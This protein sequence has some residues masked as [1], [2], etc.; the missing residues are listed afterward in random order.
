[1]YFYKGHFLSGDEMRCEGRCIQQRIS[2]VS[3]DGMYEWPAT[4][5]VR[6][7]PVKWPPATESN[8]EIHRLGPSSNLD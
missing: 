1:M 7:N 8:V 3:H 2:G 4:R 6:H 5:G